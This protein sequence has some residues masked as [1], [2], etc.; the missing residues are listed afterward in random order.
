MKKEYLKP[1][2]EIIDSLGCELLAG[3]LPVYEETISGDDILAP[4]LEEELF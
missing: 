4:S 3:S 2:M 1:T